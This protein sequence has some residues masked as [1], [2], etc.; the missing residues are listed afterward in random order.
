MI[1]ECSKKQGGSL[2]NINEPNIL[3]MPNK[4][5]SKTVLNEEER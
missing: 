5:F 4:Y 2:T 3:N 1:E